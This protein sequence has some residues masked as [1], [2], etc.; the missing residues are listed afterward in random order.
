MLI[1]VFGEER[2]KEKEKERKR[3]E[4]EEGERKMREEKRKK[5]KKKKKE[6]KRR[7]SQ[8]SLCPNTSVRVTRLQRATIS[9]ALAFVFL[10]FQFNH[11]YY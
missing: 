9:D 5:K 6:K 10:K 3:R 11:F 1:C 8:C 2:K 7:H 4:R